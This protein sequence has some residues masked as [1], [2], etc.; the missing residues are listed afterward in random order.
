MKSL[1]INVIL[2]AAFIVAG[3]CPLIAQTPE[4]LYQ[5]GLM[6]EQGEGALQDAISLYSQI[7]DNSNADLSLRAKALLHIGMCYE[8][9]GTREAVEAYQRLV[10]NFP[11]QKN[12]VAIARERLN[13][14]MPITEMDAEEP[15]GIRIRQIWKQPYLDFLGTVS[16]DGRFLSY[17]YWG[18]GDVAVHNLITGEDRILTHDADLGDSTHFA[19]CPAISKDGSKIAY[20]WWNPYH[21]FDLCL[22]D[23]DNPYPRVLYRQ[24]GMEVYPMTWLSDRELITIRQNRKTEITK[25]TSFNVL[26]GTFKDLKTFDG[27]KWAQI[28]TSPDEKFI[29]YDF[30]D[31][32][33]SENSD[34]NILPLDGGSEISLVNHPANDRVLGWVPGRREFLFISDRSGTWDLWAIPVDDGKPS[35]P[36]K[37]IYSDI[38]EVEPMGFTEDGNCFV[39][40]SMR[41]FNMYIVPFNNRTGALNVESGKAQLG[42]NFGA[43]WSPDGQYMAYTKIAEDS[44]QLT[45][46]DVIT[47][48]ERRLADDL[49]MSVAPCWSPD[50]KTILVFGR[51][52]NKLQTKG[53]SGGLYTVNVRTGQINEILLLSD[54]NPL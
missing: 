47:G 43:E 10:S 8:R 29:A 4:Q 15:E 22:I 5:K 34:I 26:D 48:I 35:L 54:Y 40:F 36:V 38:G 2:V 6:K 25:I 3:N 46:Q 53:F 27:R 1:W 14:L 37:R 24:E 51:M 21:T 12:E 41:N 32:T 18:E 19:Q 45:I 39:G 11:T 50:G 17:V 20:Y 42:S 28:A 7:A 52:K 23:V 49:S 44:Y 9:M 16:S 30:A 31:E 33:N 13:R